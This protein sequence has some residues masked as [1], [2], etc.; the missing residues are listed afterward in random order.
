MPDDKRPARAPAFGSPA[1]TRARGI[2][3]LLL[4]LAVLAQAALAASCSCTTAGCS[5]GL[6][7]SIALGAPTAGDHLDVSFDGHKLAC[8]FDSDGVCSA[9]IPADVAKELTA[10]IDGYAYVSPQFTARVSGGAVQLSSPGVAP[11]CVG[12]TLSRGGKELATTALAVTYEDTY[13]NGEHCDP[14]CRSTASTGT[15]ASCP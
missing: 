5:G 7:A 14:V 8:D 12:V 2:H 4:T 9:M 6:D 10:D 15:V 11:G 13:P 1:P 3:R